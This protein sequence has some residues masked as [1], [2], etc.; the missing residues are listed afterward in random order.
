M[1]A[2][3]VLGV[4]PSLGQSLLETHAIRQTQTAYTAVLYAERGIDL[5]RPPLPILGPPGSIPQEFPIVQAAG[6]VLIG[7]GMGADTSMRVVGLVSLLASA[8]LVFVLGRRLMSASR[9]AGRARGVPL[10]RARVGVRPYVPDRVHGDRRRHWPC[11]TSP[12]AG[13]TRAASGTGLRPLVAG[14]IGVLVK[15]TTGGFYLLPILLWRS[16][17]G[18]WGFQR[19]V[20]LGIDRR[21]GR[22]WAGVER[23]RAGGA[24]GD[25]RERLPLDGEPARAG[26]SGPPGSAST[27]RTG[28]CRSSRS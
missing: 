7:A 27:S 2:V 23:I 13:W 10:Q 4:L 28:A 18:R 3:Y 20:R 19:A 8:V 26:S 16:Q 11:S 17:L 15:I 22:G 24:R 12:F 6:A 9:C 14:C 25:P 21:V 1:V 5:L